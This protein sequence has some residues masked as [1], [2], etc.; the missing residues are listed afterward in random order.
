MRYHS[1]VSLPGTWVLAIVVT[2]FL[3]LRP[4]AAD[5]IDPHW[6]KLKAKSENRRLEVVAVPR[7][8]DRTHLADYLYTLRDAR[9]GKVVWHR[10]QPKYE[11]PPADL[12][13]SDDGRVIV[14]TS[15]SLRFVYDGKKTRGSCDPDE[16]EDEEWAGP[17]LVG[18]SA[19]TGAER[20]SVCVIEPFPQEDSHDVRFSVSNARVRWFRRNFLRVRGKLYFAIRMASDK[21]YFVDLDA[22]RLLKSPLPFLLKAADAEDARFV[23]QA[24]EKKSRYE[25]IAIMLAGRLRLRESAPLLRNFEKSNRGGLSAWD[26]SVSEDRK[27]LDIS[28]GD[29]DVLRARQR[30]QEALRQIGEKPRPLPCVRFR[31]RR[32]GKRA[33]KVKLP[34]LPGPRAERVELIKKGMTATAMLAAIGAPDY[35]HDTIDG[36]PVWDY[37]MDTSAP[38]TLR[39]RIHREGETLRRF[40]QI[41]P[42][43]WQ[44]STP[45]WCWWKEGK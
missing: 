18:L 28:I 42:A 35:I 23:M 26:C 43:C 39:L 9:N 29:Y 16:D 5:R 11:A 25:P 40:E 1:L 4:A 3:G 24:L 15:C 20:M 31:C 2:S 41:K 6:H 45:R 19:E 13:V 17:Q 27:K 37:D 22:W 38:Y 21:R 12:F 10:S 14:V 8:P 32:N 33:E 34:P 44:R 7:G 36:D 30:A